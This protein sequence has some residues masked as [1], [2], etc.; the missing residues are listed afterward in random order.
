MSIINDLVSTLPDNTD[1]YFT[2]NKQTEANQS[3][4]LL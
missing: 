3:K 4:I 2:K 1:Q